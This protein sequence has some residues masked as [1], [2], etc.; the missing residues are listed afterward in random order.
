TLVFDHP[1]VT[2]LAVFLGQKLLG[3][4]ER[5]APVVIRAAA[6]GDDPI[7]VVAMGCRFPSGIGS[8]EELWR[9][10]TDEADLIGPF[11]VDRGWP[12]H[13]L[14]DPDGAAPDSSYVDHGGFLSDAALFDPAF[15]N[16]SP[17]EAP[18]MDPQQ[19]LLLETSW[20]ALER[21]AIDP[22]T[23]RGS[24]TGVYVGVSEQGHTARLLDAATDVEGYFAT[25]AAASVA[26]GRIAYTLGLEGP[27]VT[28]DTA[29]SS[30]LVAL[31]LAVQ[32]LRAGE[33]DLALAGGATVMS[34]PASFVGFSRQQALAR[35]GRSKSFAAAADGFALGEGAAV[36][37]VERLSDARRNGHPVLAVVRGSAV[38]QDGASNGL[39]APN[40]PSQQRVI[41]DAL[42]G[43]G[44][45]PADVDAVEAHGTGT[46]LGDPIEAHALLAT[47]GQDRERPLYLG[48]L[49]SNI[50]HAQAAAGVAGVIKTVLALRHGTLPRTLHV[51]EPT[52]EVDWS[53]GAVE[54]L[55]EN[56]P[57]PDTG[58]PRR[59]GVSAFG[60]S[61]TNAHVVLEQPDTPAQPNPQPVTEPVLLPESVP[62]SESA[63]QGPSVVPLVLS[64]HDDAALRAQAARYA[65][66]LAERPDVRL[67]DLALSL[68]TTRAVLP[69]AT[70][71]TATDPDELHQALT[72]L[73]EAGATTT[74]SPAGG[75][76]AVVFSGQGS[77]RVGMG[78]G[79]YEAFPVFAAAFDEVCGAFEGL[80]PGSLKEVVFEGPAEVL[81]STGWAQPALF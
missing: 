53:A 49:K 6:D 60:I 31:H 25:G 81:E 48:S 15:F 35:D 59:A 22:S 68:A 54:L 7:A 41:L 29:C 79:L 64:A 80:L 24:R 70:V 71:L 27:A 34:E 37:V 12:L 5:Q 8:P 16:I 45:S 69:T 73:A 23:L 9:A 44:L 72:G 42:A 58:R 2:A 57:W 47:Y 75:G 51:D 33:C 77:Q 56:R 18:A 52:P 55:T 17:R 66:F 4:R 74:D 43:A 32:A 21:A 28:V 20:E 67:P 3:E 65:A 19:R 78:R 50:G 1:T 46:R 61:G 10:L 36:L 13:R 11:P 63:E 38:N 62:E 26:S 30:S 76:L 14:H 39:T 40:G